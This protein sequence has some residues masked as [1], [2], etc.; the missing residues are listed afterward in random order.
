[1]STTESRHCIACG[2][3]RVLRRV[4]V[5]ALLCALLSGIAGMFMLNGLPQPYHPLF[6]APNFNRASSDKFFLCIEVEDPQ[7]DAG[8]TRAFMESLDAVQVTQ[9][10]LKK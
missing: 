7:Y 8:K 4:V 9:V 5:S 1:M 3:V 6:D 10:M 2:P